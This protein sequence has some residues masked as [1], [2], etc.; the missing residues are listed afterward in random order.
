[1]KKLIKKIY[2]GLPMKKQVFSILRL[3]HPPQKIYQHL[4]FKGPF[5]VRIG[6]GFSINHYGF[7]LE[8]ELFWGGLKQWESLSLK[9]WTELSKSANTILDV[10]ANTGIY[11][12]I[13]GAVHPNARIYAIEPLKSVYER[14]E[15]N[16]KMNQLPIKA[17][18]L[19][20]SNKN[21]RA[22]FYTNDADFSYGSS[23]NKNHQSC[24]NKIEQEV[25]TIL[26]DHFIEQNH[27]IPDLIKID[28]ERHEP[29]VIEGLHQTIRKH[30][31]T[32]FI[33]VLDENIGN[34]LK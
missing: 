14:L 12:L 26:L 7:Q 32:M 1:V 20:A 15:E 6:Q 30:W 8:N 13:A 28:V 21:G 29:E 27:I 34:R 24:S 22:S 5:K 17:Y 25:E 9:L 10:G 4:S 23:L 33:E 3:L 16:L 2:N 31:P 11:S 18:D 19:A